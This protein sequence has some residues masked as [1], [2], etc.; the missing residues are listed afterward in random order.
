MP[1]KAIVEDFGNAVFGSIENYGAEVSLPIKTAVD[2]L[3]DMAGR[4]WPSEVKVDQ[5]SHTISAFDTPALMAEAEL[6]MSW[7]WPQINT[8]EAIDDR[9]AEYVELWQPLLEAVQDDSPVWVMRD[10]HSPNLIWLAE[11]EGNARVGIIDTQD[12]VLGSPA[13]D[14][15]SLLQ[16]ARL[17]V[18]ANV[19]SEMLNHYAACRR[20]EDRAFDE[21]K[22]RMSYAILGAQR[23]AKILG[24]F[25]RLSKRDGK[26]GYLR[27]IPRVSRLLERNL[28]HP[29]LADLKAW[30]DRYL[31]PALRETA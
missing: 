3:A 31:P 4:A 27:H 28:Q 26:P 19:E 21:A 14:L 20:S 13:Y 15:A 11:R 23:A 6:L 22:F 17:D 18:A 25:A 16:D 24:I 10:Y 2:V 29:A 7:F 12:A 1:A 30:F 9:R 8:V 5:T